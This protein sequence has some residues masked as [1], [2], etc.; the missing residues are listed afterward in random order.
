[1]YILAHRGCWRDESEKNTPFALHYALESGFGI[2]SDIRDYMGELVISHNIADATCQKADEVFCWLAKFQN[3]FCFAI[4]IKADG[5]GNLLARL[6]KTYGITNYFTFDMS[7][8]QMV[9]YVEMGLK[10]FTRQ[11]EVEPDPIMYDT[12]SGVWID[13][14]W[15]TE[16]ITD[17]LLQGHISQGKQ[18]CLVSPELHKRNP[19]EFWNRLKSFELNWDNVILCTDRPVEAA[20]FFKERLE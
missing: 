5:L 12:A 20:E 3:Q 6:L 17:T 11:S 2:E 4:N 14:F 9:E 13:G 8:P 15:G 1:M 19:Q 16:W 10:Y 18:I 7:V